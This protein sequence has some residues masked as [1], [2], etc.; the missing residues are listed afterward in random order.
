MVTS[1]WFIGINININPSAILDY[2]L[3]FSEWLDGDVLQQVQ[4]GATGCTGVV[5]SN[6]QTSARIRV[7]NVAV[8]GKVV[9]TVVTATGQSD[10]FTINFT[11][12]VQ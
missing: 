6:T 3:D 7:S 11:A 10:S 12:K 9:V 4:A 8:R 1:K 5:R 2:D